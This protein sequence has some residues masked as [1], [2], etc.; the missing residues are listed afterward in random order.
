MQ[1]I[2]D[3]VS[4]GVPA[5]LVE[6]VTLGRTLKKRAADVLAYFDRPR[7]SNGPTEARYRPVPL[8][9]DGVAGAIAPMCRS[10]LTCRASVSGGRVG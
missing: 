3:S 4:H 9:S 1:Q 6:V 8:R 5:A 2:I 10:S 7:T